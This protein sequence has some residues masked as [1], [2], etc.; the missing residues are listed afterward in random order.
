MCWI[1]FGR[2]DQIQHF[3]ANAQLNKIS[4]MIGCFVSTKV[5]TLFLNS[6]V[7]FLQT[8][9]ICFIFALMAFHSFPTR[10]AKI[11]L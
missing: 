10:L 11:W 8:V 5:S 4:L 7:T 2:S 3:F 9:A 6:G 1:T